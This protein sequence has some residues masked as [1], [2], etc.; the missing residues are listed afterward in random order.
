MSCKL[1]ILNFNSA[2]FFD[3]PKMFDSSRYLEYAIVKAKKCGNIK[4]EDSCALHTCDI[5]FI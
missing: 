5:V 4:V 3:F 2:N 1:T